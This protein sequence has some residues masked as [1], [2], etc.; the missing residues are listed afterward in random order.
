MISCFQS[1]LY[2]SFVNKGYG[3]LHK[4]YDNDLGAKTDRGGAW[5]ATKGQLGPSQGN[6]QCSEDTVG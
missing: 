3:P 6:Q 2:L 5:S 4:A 1:Y